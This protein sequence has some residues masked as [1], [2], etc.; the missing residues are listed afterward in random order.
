MMML[1][2]NHFGGDYLPTSQPANQETT[3]LSD[4]HEE[5]KHR[6]SKQEKIKFS[7]A[8]LEEKKH[9]KNIFLRNV[10]FIRANILG[11]K[12]SDI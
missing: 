11:C 12:C 4:W 8:C 7:E 10:F 5:D 3:V 1:I 2:W 9:C 6:K